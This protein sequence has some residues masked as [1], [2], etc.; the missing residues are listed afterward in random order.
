MERLLLENNPRCKVCRKKMDY[1]EELI[2]QDQSLQVYTCFSCK[3][4][5]LRVKPIPQLDF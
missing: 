5:K 3:T 1:L 4:F 2:R